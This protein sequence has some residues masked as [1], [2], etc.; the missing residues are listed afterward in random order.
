MKPSDRARMNNSKPHTASKFGNEPCHIGLSW[1]IIQFTQDGGALGSVMKTAFSLD[2]DEFML[3]WDGH[4]KELLRVLTTEGTS[5]LGANPNILRGPR[6]K[7]V[8]GHDLW[9]RV[10]VK[11]FNRAAKMEL[12]RN[13]QNSVAREEYLKPALEIARDYGFST[14]GEIAVLFDMSVQYGPSRARSKVRKLS[15]KKENFTIVDVINK[16]TGKR[17][18]NRRKKILRDSEI[19]IIYDLTLDRG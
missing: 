15:K 19:F 8:G 12:F 17:A 11:R 7:K 18:R 2:P 14:Q 4:G 5:G 3:P 16:L 9:E 10:W 6:V 13:A 1:G